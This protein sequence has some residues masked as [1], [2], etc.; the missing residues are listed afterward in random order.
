MGGG[1]EVG[2]HF[3]VIVIVG[4]CL[5]RCMACFRGAGTEYVARSLFYRNTCA[6]VST[7]VNNAQ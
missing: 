4:V 7:L 1:E 2:R 6:N 3:L 5:C